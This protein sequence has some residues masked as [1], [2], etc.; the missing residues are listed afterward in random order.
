MLVTLSEIVMLVRLVHARNALAPIRS[1]PSGITSSVIS[2][3][4]RYNLCVKN[5][6]LAKSPSNEILHHASM[7]LIC[8]SSRLSQPKNAE[9]PMLVTLSG[10]VMLIR[11]SQAENAPLPILVTGLF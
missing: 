3:P 11:L 4:S 8:T 2:S 5:S 7:L 10:I 6:G 9:L 1:T